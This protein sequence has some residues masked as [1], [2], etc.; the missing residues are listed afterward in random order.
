MRQPLTAFMQRAWGSGNSTPT[1]E[2]DGT[3]VV[4]PGAGSSTEP[5]GGWPSPMA[6]DDDETG[7]AVERMAD[8][9][10]YGRRGINR[11]VAP[12]RHE[13]A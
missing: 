2:G 12:K 13:T 11:P 8:R 10:A 3:P 4:S 5:P 1:G 6:L 7:N 9:L